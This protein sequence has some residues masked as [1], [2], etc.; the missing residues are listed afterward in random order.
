MRS[1][2]FAAVLAY[3]GEAP[4]LRKGKAYLYPFAQG[5]EFWR[6]SDVS[7][8]AERV[9]AGGPI[10]YAAL[11]YIEDGDGNPKSGRR[12]VR[13]RITVREDAGRVFLRL[14]ESEWEVVTA[15]ECDCGWCRIPG[16]PCESCR[17]W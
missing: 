8:L 3:E 9:S 17:K 12:D 4:P 7:R 2:V 6:E 5:G 15:P 11:W 14:D 10:H 1:D 13:G 16:R